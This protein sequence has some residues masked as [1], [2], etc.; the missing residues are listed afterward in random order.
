MQHVPGWYVESA[1]QTKALTKII[2]SI[3]AS[4]GKSDITEASATILDWDNGS[5]FFHC[6]Q[7]VSASIASFNQTHSH[8]RT[9]NDIQC[10]GFCWTIT[11]TSSIATLMVAQYLICTTIYTCKGITLGKHSWKLSN[12][13]KIKAAVSY[14]SS[15]SGIRWIKD[16]QLG[17]GRLAAFNWNYG[18]MAV[19]KCTMYL[20]SV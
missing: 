11:V 16:T 9:D 15:F 19:A 20:K 1:A 17:V 7:A 10:T 5:N 18:V 12:D 13:Y 2:I 8:R 3:A 6:W 4:Q 14:L